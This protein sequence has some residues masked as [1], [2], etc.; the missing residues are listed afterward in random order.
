MARRGDLPLALCAV[1]K[2]DVRELKTIQDWVIDRNLRAVAG[3][4]DIV[5]FGWRGEDFEVR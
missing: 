2:R 4:A 3:V 1:A 5:S